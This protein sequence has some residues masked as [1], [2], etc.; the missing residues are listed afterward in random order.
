M[1]QFYSNHNNLIILDKMI[2]S[3]RYTKLWHFSP[4][5]FYS[6]VPPYLPSVTNVQGDRISDGFS[7]YD[8]LNSFKT[9][10][11]IDNDPILCLL[12][13]LAAKFIYEPQRALAYIFNFSHHSNIFDV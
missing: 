13:K 1:F 9:N 3:L 7:L 11:A 12:I 6:N 8:I 5:F 2:L 10:K 4:G